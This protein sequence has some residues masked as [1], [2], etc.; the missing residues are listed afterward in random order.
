MAKFNGPRFTF[1]V[2]IY[3][4]LQNIRRKFCNE[5]NVYLF[6]VENEKNSILTSAYVYGCFGE[7][8]YDYDSNAANGAPLIL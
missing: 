8:N 5:Q 7:I 1:R 6:A 4:R 2:C 3:S